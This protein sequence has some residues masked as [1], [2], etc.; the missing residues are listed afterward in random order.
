MHTKLTLVSEDLV[1]RNPKHCNHVILDSSEV[2]LITDT[3]LTILIIV[4]MVGILN[5]NIQINFH[6]LSNYM[7]ILYLNTFLVEPMFS[8]IV[9]S[10]LKHIP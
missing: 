8:V 6:I 1:I 10:F 2:I 4:S 3:L 5:P 9:I 7:S